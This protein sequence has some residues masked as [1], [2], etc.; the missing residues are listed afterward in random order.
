[1]DVELHLRYVGTDGDDST[2]AL[3]ELGES[4]VGFDYVFRELTRILRIEGGV[5]VSATESREGSVVIDILLQLS[6]AADTLF[7]SVQAFLTALEL[8]KDPLLH[9]ARDYFHELEVAHRTLNDWVAAHP[10]DAAAITAI[11][12]KA[13]KTLIRRARQHKRAPDLSDREVP[14]PIAE[15]LHKLVRKGAFKKALTPIT[16]NAA[17]KIEVSDDRSFR[18]P[19]AIDDSNLEEYLA[20][21][22]QILPHLKDGAFEHLTGKV[23][24][25]R[26]TRGDALTFHL[27]HEGRTYNLDAYPPIGTTSKAFKDFYQE[28]VVIGAWV[29]RDSLYKKPRLKIDRIE[30]LQPELGLDLGITKS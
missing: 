23:T 20:D 6:N 9:A 21:E 19:A 30:L 27:E 22:Q 28:D 14:R 7:D 15:E 10:V 12:A 26:G 1:M 18:D 8:A 17:K 25:L 24:S 29:V 13:Y 2:I 16:D 11:L 3:S 5:E 4:L